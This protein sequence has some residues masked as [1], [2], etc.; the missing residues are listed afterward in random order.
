MRVLPLLCAY[1]VVAPLTLARA[2]PRRTLE[3]VTLRKKPG[4]KEAVVARLP[5][6]TP[7]TV[8]ALEGRRLVQVR[9]AAA[10]RQTLDQQPLARELISAHGASR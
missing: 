1:A 6:G 4:E 7:V 3:E 5:A 10:A 9:A 8:L 2:E